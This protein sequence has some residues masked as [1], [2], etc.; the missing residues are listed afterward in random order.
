[1]TR[2]ILYSFRRCPYAMRARLAIASAAIP[3][4]HREILLRDKPEA[5]LAASPKGTVPVVIAGDQVID[6]SIDVMHWALRQ[7]DPEN[8]LEIPE[9][10]HDLIAT[11][12]G[13]FKSSLD[14]YKYA[15]RFENADPVQDRADAS[16]YLMGLNTMLNG[17]SFLFGPEPSLADMAILPFIR[18]FAHVDIYWFNLQPWTELARW[19]TEF[20]ASP[21]FT[22]IM[23]KHTLWQPGTTTATDGTGRR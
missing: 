4:E 13:P 7:N 20:K 17:R 12:D 5:M 2:P 8:W 22:G 6:E 1:M 18:Q 21:R 23:V 11:A 16:A 19:L 10:A 15:S 3:V 14:R 9:A